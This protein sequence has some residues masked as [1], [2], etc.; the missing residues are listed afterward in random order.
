MQ[1]DSFFP[2]NH[3][4]FSDLPIGNVLLYAPTII[5]SQ[6]HIEKILRKPCQYIP[7]ALEDQNAPA[8]D[9]K[10][11]LNPH[12]PQYLILPCL[13]GSFIKMCFADPVLLHVKI[14]DFGESFITVPGSSSRIQP[15][16]CPTFVHPLNSCLIIYSALHRTSGPLPT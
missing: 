11:C 4:N 14:C 1:L 8:S 12:S 7:L 16:H 13:K 10:S 5:S 2:S 15:S 9:S 6:E 3:T